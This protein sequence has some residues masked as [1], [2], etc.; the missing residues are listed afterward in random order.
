MSLI[1]VL[2]LRIKAL[3]VVPTPEIASQVRTTIE[4]L[5]TGFEV[6]IGMLVPGGEFA[7]SLHVF[8]IFPNAQS[9]TGD[10]T[11][12]LATKQIVIAT[13]G[14]MAVEIRRSR[15]LFANVVV[16]TLD[17]ADQLFKDYDSDISS[18]KRFNHS[19]SLA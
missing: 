14:P 19:A 1:F 18:L 17:E 10:S 13:P 8:P 7:R 3:C 4:K 11:A 5:T 16:V 12:E 2:T 15:D 9:N 6:S